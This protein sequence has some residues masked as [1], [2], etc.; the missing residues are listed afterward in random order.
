MHV[1]RW[2]AHRQSHRQSYEQ[3]PQKAG[4][5]TT[6]SIRKS[7]VTGSGL[8]HLTE[9]CAVHMHGHWHTCTQFVIG[10]QVRTVSAGKLNKETIMGRKSLCEKC[11]G[12]P[13]LGGYRAPDNTQ[14]RPP[15][16]SSAAAIL[17]RI[18]GA[19]HIRVCHELRCL[20][21]IKHWE[22]WNCSAPYAVWLTGS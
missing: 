7:R 4:N 6:V 20:V 18:S 10:T 1:H 21:R 16:Q 15:T 22:R 2:C 12:E 8:Q 13:R 3:P 17:R 9:Q 14:T 5:T 11:T 19:Y